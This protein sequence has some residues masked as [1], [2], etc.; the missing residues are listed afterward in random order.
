[1]ASAREPVNNGGMKTIEASA[2]TAASRDEVWR[3]IADHTTWLEWGRWSRVEIEGG[4]EHGLGAIRRLV[5]WPFTVRERITEWEPG[6]RMSYELLEG[7]NARGYR[8]SAI[9]EDAPAGGTV[10][11]WRS[12]YERADPITAFLL[13]AAARD[14]VKRI[15]RAA[16]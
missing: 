8:A 6:E 11:R 15:A 13:G 7:M 12:Q 3:L 5:Q 14:T 4:G 16:G 9:L 1:M 10:V 2:T